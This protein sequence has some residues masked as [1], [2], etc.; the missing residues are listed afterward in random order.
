MQLQ[1]TASFKY[2]LRDYYRRALRVLES[3]K[4]IRWNEEPQHIGCTSLESIF[5]IE[6]PEELQEEIERK[7]LVRFPVYSLDQWHECKQQQPDE[8]INI[9]EMV[10]AVK[11]A[12]L[13]TL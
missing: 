10:Q 9:A 5:T 1:Y 11:S 4:G 13:R 3:K 2:R 7:L 6:C 12:K 8:F